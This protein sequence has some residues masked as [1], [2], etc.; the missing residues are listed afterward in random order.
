MCLILYMAADSGVSLIP[1]DKANP[2]FHV[3]MPS[4][5]GDAKVRGHFSKPH[6]VCLGSHEGCGCG[7][8]HSELA[9][10][11]DPD[12][13]PE[14]VAQRAESMRRL[15]EYLAHTVGRTGAVELYLCWDG[16]QGH[17]A[18]S[19]EDVSCAQV[20]GPDYAVPIRKLVTVKA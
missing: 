9:E 1:W 4:A 7:F 6:I 2:A 8:R 14:E 11:F 17:E 5:P 3:S 18:L 15:G 13:D 16:D 12:P 19:S 20:Q 10:W